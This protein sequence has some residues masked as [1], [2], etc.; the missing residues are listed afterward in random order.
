MEFKGQGTTDK[1][2]TQILSET[3]LT[4]N[5]IASSQW[6]LKSKGCGDLRSGRTSYYMDNRVAQIVGKERER[7]G[8]REIFVVKH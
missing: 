4:K 1:R 8:E 7:G 6:M 5:Q 2:L 3:G